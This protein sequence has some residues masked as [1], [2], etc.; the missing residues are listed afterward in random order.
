MRQHVQTEPIECLFRRADTLQILELDGCT[1]VWFLRKKAACAVKYWWE[2]WGKESAPC[3]LVFVPVCSLHLQML[4]LGSRVRAVAMLGAWLLCAWMQ[5]GGRNERAALVRDWRTVISV[6][7]MWEVWSVYLWQEWAEVC[8][9]VPLP[10]L[11]ERWMLGWEQSFLS[12]VIAFFTTKKETIIYCH[13]SSIKPFFLFFFFFV[14]SRIFCHLFH[15]FHSSIGGL[16]T[17]NTNSNLWSTRWILTAVRKCPSPFSVVVLAG[18][19]EKDG[20]HTTGFPSKSAS[21][22]FQWTSKRCASLCCRTGILLESI[23]KLK[24]GTALQATTT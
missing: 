7:R 10:L 11:D 16:S 20:P 8:R 4:F 15:F 14:R 6:V 2:R 23:W 24:Y 18:D 19:G 1:H 5:E 9:S 12:L 3:P 21:T 22:D 17:Q 13:K